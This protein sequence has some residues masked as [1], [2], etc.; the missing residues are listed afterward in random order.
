MKS[1][2]IRFKD[3]LCTVKVTHYCDGGRAAIQLVD[4][5]DGSPVAVATVNIPEYPLAPDEAIIKDYSENEGMLDVLQK[6]GIVKEVVG[7]VQTGYVTCPVVRLDMAR[8][9]GKEV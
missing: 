3:W 7:S 8:L 4:A 5:Y 2:K 6:A 9:S 1:M